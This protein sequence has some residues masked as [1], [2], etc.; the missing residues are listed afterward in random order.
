MFKKIVAGLVISAM[1]MSAF[2]ADNVLIQFIDGTQAMY[3]NVPEDW[4]NNQFRQHVRK[5]HSKEFSIIKVEP[6]ETEFWDSGWG[7]A[8]KV[9]IAV[10]AGAV[11]WKLSAG[12][13]AGCQHYY[14]RAKD[15]SLCG[16]R[17]ADYRPGGK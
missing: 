17:S 2:A 9:A 13:S 1:S 6:A 14:D 3:K 16:K 4:D 8:A 10:T 11:L 5:D 12:M 15:G 7:T